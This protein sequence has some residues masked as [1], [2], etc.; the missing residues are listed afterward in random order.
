MTQDI[1]DI[2]LQHVVEAQLHADKTLDSADITVAVK[3]RVATPAGF[4]RSFRQRRRAVAAVERV[5]GVAAIVDDIE[6]RLPLLHRRTDPEIAGN[7]LETLRLDLPEA[8]ENL[9]VTVDDGSW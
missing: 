1:Q 2:E 6:V 3:D 7:A 9:K 5:R 8:A 4:T